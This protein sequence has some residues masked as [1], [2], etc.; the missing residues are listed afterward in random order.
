MTFVDV[1][2]AV[3]VAV[4]AVA[5]AFTAMSKWTPTRWLL[6]QLGKAMYAGFVEP[7]V[8]WDE[9][10]S[11]AVAAQIAAELEGR[12]LSR[13]DV[14]EAQ[15]TKVE[16]QY[17]TNGGSTVKDDLLAIRDDIRGIEHRMNDRHDEFVDHA[18]SIEGRI[19]ALE[20]AVGLR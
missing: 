13:L 14:I 11:E 2:V 5:G 8:A 15:L 9:G 7:F 10:R 16:A 12:L 1:V 4:G 19:E 3:I 18:T 17:R 20:V 6:R